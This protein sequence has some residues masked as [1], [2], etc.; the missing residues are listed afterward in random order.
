MRKKYTITVL[1]IALLSLILIGGGA[2]AASSDE[3]F[4]N[5]SGSP[6][7]GS[8]STSY[9]IGAN[10]TGLIGSDT[11]YALSASG[12][13]SLTST[14]A[15]GGGGLVS[16]NGTVRIRS[17][18]IKV[19]LKYYYSTF[20]DSGLTAANLQNETGSGYAFGYYDNDRQFVE[21]G[22]TAETRI[23]MKVTSGTGIGVYITGT[24]ILLCQVD[25]TSSGSMLAVQ[26]L[27]DS[28]DAVTWFSGNKYYGGFEYAVLGAGKISVINV[29]DIEKYT[30]G[31]CAS[32]M[33]ERW[34]LEAL[35]AQ[36]VA[37]RTYGQKSIKNTVYYYSC[38]FD[39]TSD[40]Y[41]QAYSG[42]TNV[43]Q[44]I[45]RAVTETE[46]QYLT[47][48]GALIDALYFSSDG[49]ATED[50]L[51]VNG[52]SGHPYLAGVIDPYEAAADAINGFSSWSVEMT[53][54]QL[55]AKVGLSDVAEVRVTN[56]A[57][58]NVIGLEFVSSSGEIATVQRDACRTK[59]GLYSIRYTISR[60][61]DGN[62]VFDGS[63]WGHNLGMSQYGAY[64]MANYYG[65]TYKDILGF[66]YTGVSLSYGEL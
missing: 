11:V 52:N 57:T 63:G 60:N 43:G 16:D 44:T 35:K 8:F 42:C 27:C 21:Q 25:S 40:T 48:N 26:P 36:A 65:K 32:E 38:G 24:D 19:G 30:M 47:Y 20:R 17:D 7:K 50:N 12:L 56:S 2:L 1:L 45:T 34:P 55:G 33:N 3:I 23:T 58:G 15:V 51:N 39:V 4:V 13:H 14:G 22:R 41:C 46:N 9:A 62:Y 31:V 64:A 10:G 66:Y 37:A 18:V 54:Q 49:G 29:V 28:G 59:L 6:F 61:S 53:P 5:F